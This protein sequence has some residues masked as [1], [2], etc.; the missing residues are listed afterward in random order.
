MA[1]NFIRMLRAGP[2]VSFRGSPTVSPTTAALCKSVPLPW[3]SLPTLTQPFSTY[4]LALSQAPPVLA[5][6]MASWTPEVRLPTSKPHTHSTPKKAPVMIG[7]KMTS[8]PGRTISLKEASVEI[9]MHWLWS[10]SPCPG[11]PSR[12]PGISRNWRSTSLTMDMAAVP[13]DFMHRAVNQYGSIAPM[14]KK[15]KVVGRNTLMT[16]WPSLT[17]PLTRAMKPPNSARDTRAAEPMAKPFPMAAVVL[18][19]ASRA[20]VLSRTDSGNSD[21]SAIPPALSQTGP[22]TSIDKQVARVPNIPN[23]AMATPYIPTNSKDMNTVPAIK[24][25]GRIADFIPKARP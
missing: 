21:I 18:P 14:N 25:M 2:E 17:S 20:S 12:S 7:E 4:F 3:T 1:C 13:T 23:A 5:W 10:G 6:E 16:T 15:E 11:V 22:Y 8:R 9:L 19:A 24:K